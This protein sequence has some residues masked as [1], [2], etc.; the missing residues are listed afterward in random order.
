MFVLVEV[1]A[2]ECL[3]IWYEKEGQWQ[4]TSTLSLARNA[5]VVVLAELIKET[6]E[7]ITAISGIGLRIA[8]KR[9]TTVR[10]VVTA[11]NTLA[12]AFSVPIVSVPWSGV[13]EELPSLLAK[14]SLG[15]YVMP[16]YQAPPRL[17]GAAIL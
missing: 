13:P 2:E 8:S 7:L 14:A 5:T 3:R 15:Q 1:T 9:F 16:E 10:L 11:A 6:G 17:G 4:K 12:L